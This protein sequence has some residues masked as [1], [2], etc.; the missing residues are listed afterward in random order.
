MPRQPPAQT[1]WRGGVGLE[2]SWL[3]RTV[4][5]AVTRDAGC[6]R[7]MFLTT[8]LKHLIS[9]LWNF[10]CRCLSLTQACMNKK[11]QLRRDPPVDLIFEEF[12]RQCSPAPRE[13]SL[14]APKPQATTVPAIAHLPA[15]GG[16]EPVISASPRGYET[17][18]PPPT[19]TP[20]SAKASTHQVE[21]RRERPKPAVAIQPMFLTY[22]QVAELLNVSDRTVQNL[23][24]RGKIPKPRLVSPNRIGFRFEDIRAYA[25][26]CPESDIPPPPN[27]NWRTS[28][29]LIQG[30]LLPLR[31]VAEML[32][33]STRTVQHLVGAGL[34][35]KPKQISARRVGY[36]LEDIQAYIAQRPESTQLPPANSGWKGMPK[37]VE[38]VPMPPRTSAA[39]ASRGNITGAR[40]DSTGELPRVGAVYGVPGTTLVWHKQVAV[41]GIP[42]PFAIAV[43]Q[44]GQTWAE[45]ELMGQ[46]RESALQRLRNR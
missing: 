27:A 24:R 45:M 23:V 29:R 2:A 35:A 10:L 40:R 12:V 5:R 43:I 18:K 36:S 31:A 6:R 41:G 20:K 8:G 26:Q 32:S 22:E 34:L 42:R 3:E 44:D 30:G 17:S 38:A 9:T 1:K 15:A 13:P 46:A 19:A 4:S 21:Q 39:P 25:D 16:W 28:H 14:Q 7:A 37:Q 33:V 11:T